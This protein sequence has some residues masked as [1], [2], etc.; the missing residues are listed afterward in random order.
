MQEEIEKKN[1]EKIV[2]LVEPDDRVPSGY[3]PD[4]ARIINI[5]CKVQG[6]YEYPSSFLALVKA[7][8]RVL[9]SEGAEPSYFEFFGSG[10][11]A[12]IVLAACLWC[13]DHGLPLPGSVVLDNPVLN[14]LEGLYEVYFSSADVDDPCA[15]PLIADYYGFPRITVMTGED[16]PL[17][18]Q[19]ESL[20][21]RLKVQDI[22]FEKRII[23]N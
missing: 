20:C 21:D 13:R 17:R 8:R 3:V 9:S 1:T 7:W 11:C 18:E 16:S 5:D 19:A 12:G 23:T 2:L 15:F 4:N 6:R 22:P 14:T 10:I